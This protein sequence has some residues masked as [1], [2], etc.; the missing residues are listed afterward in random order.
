MAWNQIGIYGIVSMR[1]RGPAWTDA[2]DKT[3]VED[4]HEETGSQEGTKESTAPDVAVLEHAGWHGC[5]LLLPDLD[6]DE[7]GDQDGEDHEQ[8]DDASTL[9]GVDGATPLQGE[10]QANDSGNEEKGSFQIH[11]SKLL[12]EG[13]ILLDFFAGNLE[14]EDDE[15]GGDEAERQVD[16]ETPAPRDVIRECASH[17]TRKRS[18]RSR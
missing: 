8:G 10:Q 11:L 4:H 7:A 14:E 18:V 2:R 5:G 15:D 16:V 17:P 1:K 9:P 3:H 12:H 13:Q 6:P